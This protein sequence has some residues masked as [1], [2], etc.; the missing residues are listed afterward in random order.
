MHLVFLI[1]VLLLIAA[2]VHHILNRVPRL[3]HSAGQWGLGESDDPR[4]AVAGMMYAVATEYGPLSPEQERHILAQLTDR[5]GLDPQVARLCLTGG[6]RVARRLPGDLNSR[7]HRLLGPIE[8]K[9]SPQEK[10]DVIEMLTIAAG[11]NA[12]RIGPVRDGI[13]RL[14]GKLLRS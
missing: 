7:L 2:I 1:L 9:C 5:I 11:G 4:I 13:S 8:S 14:S 6:K 12:Q 3:P 10:A